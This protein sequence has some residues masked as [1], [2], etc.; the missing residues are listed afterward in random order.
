[1]I[2]ETCP[3]A[4]PAEPTK[5]KEKEEEEEKS[6]LIPRPIRSRYAHLVGIDII[7][8]SDL[9]PQVLELNDRPSMHVTVSFED[10]LKSHL[11]AEIFEHVM[12]NGDIYGDSPKSGWSLIYPTDSKDKNTAALNE[13]VEKAKKATAFGEITPPQNEHAYVTKEKPKKSK[14]GKK[15]KKSKL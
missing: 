3:E 14:K 10:E 5:P 15:S 1:M 11:V 12:P 6:P 2:H 4:P 8:D 7:L 9:N 13:I